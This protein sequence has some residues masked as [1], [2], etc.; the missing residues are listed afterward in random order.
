MGRAS[1]RLRRTTV[2]AVLI[3]LTLLGLGAAGWPVYARPATNDV[4]PARPAD[5]IVVL[6]GIPATAVTGEALW[7]AGAARELVV[8]N[9]YPAGYPDLRPICPAV[10]RPHVTCFVPDPSTTRGEAQ[11]IGRLARQRGWD[12]VVVLAPVFQ[13]S[14]ARVLVER[15]YPGRLRMVDAHAPFPTS[16]WPYQYVY[17]TAGYVKVALRRSC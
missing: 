9:P 1:R 16:S 13:I 17:Q 12:D 8:S 14:R 11:E 6:G 7:R 10:P 3:T 2:V 4:S 5:A 15:C